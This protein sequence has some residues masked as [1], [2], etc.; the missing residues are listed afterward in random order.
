VFAVKVRS[1]PVNVKPPTCRVA[2]TVAVLFAV[3]TL[4][5]SGRVSSGTTCVGSGVAKPT[6]T[7]DCTDPSAAKVPLGL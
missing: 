4:T 5:P 1:L 3:S 2:L 6:C 7:S